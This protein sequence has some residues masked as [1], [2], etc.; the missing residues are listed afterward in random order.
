MSGGKKRV[1]VAVAAIGVCRA[2]GAQPIEGRQAVRKKRFR[3]GGGNPCPG[4]RGHAAGADRRAIQG[5][6]VA[7]GD[8]AFVEHRHVDETRHRNVVPDQP[9]KRS[10]DRPPADEGAGAVDRVDHP[11][12]AAAA[13]PRGMF[14]AEDLV[15]RKGRDDGVAQGKFGGL[16]GHRDRRVIGLPFD[17]AAAAEPLRDDR[18]ADIG[19]RS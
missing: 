1:I 19:K 7:H 14:L 12:V 8:I 16:V 15:I 2:G 11:A 17:G 6:P 3:R 5:R 4:K 13:L 18:P 9:D 10:E